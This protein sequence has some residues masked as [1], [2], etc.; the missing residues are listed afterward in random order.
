MAIG[1]H[2]NR[3]FVMLHRIIGREHGTDLFLCKFLKRFSLLFGSAECGVNEVRV[4]LADA[5]E[6]ILFGNKDLACDGDVGGVVLHGT[7][8][9]RKKAIPLGMRLSNAAWPIV[10]AFAGRSGSSM[11]EQS[12]RNQ[13]AKKP[14]TPLR[15]DRRSD[16][17]RSSC[18]RRLGTLG[19]GEKCAFML[20]PNLAAVKVLRLQSF[21]FCIINRNTLCLYA[22]LYQMERSAFN[23]ICYGLARAAAQFRVL[24]GC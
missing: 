15:S 20:L 14:H 8:G 11:M 2:I 10:Q 13:G 18:S 1:R 21:V 24:C 17:E 6:Q 3:R 16:P 19:E 23:P 22:D 4:L 5:V 9:S 12:E 7:R